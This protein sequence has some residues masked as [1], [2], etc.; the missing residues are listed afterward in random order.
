MPDNPIPAITKAAIARK[1]ESLR[2]EGRAPGDKS[3]SHRSIIFGALASGTTT[4]SGL[5]E[6]ADIMSTVSAMQALGA[7][8]AGSVSARTTILL[9]GP[10]AGSKLG[11]AQ[12]LEVEVIDEAAFLSLLEQHGVVL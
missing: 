11:K 9:A 8:V 2:G 5:L 10:G 7:K 1:S 3:I 12:D 4:V 6:G